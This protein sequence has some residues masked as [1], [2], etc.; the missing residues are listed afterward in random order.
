MDGFR[1]HCLINVL[2]NKYGNRAVK[3]G[4]FDSSGRNAFSELYVGQSGAL[5]FAR[6]KPCSLVKR[7]FI[8]GSIGFKDFEL[9]IKAGSQET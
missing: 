7:K 8:F 1:Y 9:S 4:N 3:K 6:G 2:V 5:R